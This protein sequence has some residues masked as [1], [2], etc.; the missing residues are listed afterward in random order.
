MNLEIIR[1]GPK[2]VRRGETT[3]YEEEFFAFDNI[4][5]KLF[6]ISK[7]VSYKSFMIRTPLINRINKSLKK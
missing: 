1:C 7:N 2:T 4:S 5:W 3:P 6:K